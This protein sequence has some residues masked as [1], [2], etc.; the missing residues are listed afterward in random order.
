MKLNSTF[1]RRRAGANFRMFQ[2]YTVFLTSLV[3][4]NWTII[5]TTTVNIDRQGCFAVTLF[6]FKEYWNGIYTRCT[7]TQTLVTHKTLSGHDWL[8]GRNLTIRIVVG[9]IYKYFGIFHRFEPKSP[10]NRQLLR[11]GNSR[12]AVCA[13]I[14]TPVWLHGWQLGACIEHPV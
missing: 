12:C 3:Q 10:Q 7:E 5:S 8:Y 4:F 2:S 1:W 9:L 11:S 14:C 6:Y 13:Y